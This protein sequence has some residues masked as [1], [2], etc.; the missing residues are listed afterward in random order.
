MY[1]IYFLSHQDACYGTMCI[2]AGPPTCEV[3]GKD[4]KCIAGYYPEVTTDGI[5][6][7]KYSLI[8]IIIMCDKSCASRL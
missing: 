5:C 1:F 4:C 8:F 7:S 2:D 3:D 6:I